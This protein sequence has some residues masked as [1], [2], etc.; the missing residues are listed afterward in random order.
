MN[1]RPTGTSTRSKC[2]YSSSCRR[3]VPRVPENRR[4]RDRALGLLVR[5][6]YPV[7]LA[8]DA[9]RRYAGAPEPE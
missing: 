9:L 7:D 3:R 5:R 2:V 4:E 8:Y 6:G 1:P